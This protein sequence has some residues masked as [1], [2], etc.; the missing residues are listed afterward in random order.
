MKKK[1]TNFF[2][3]FFVSYSLLSIYV[4]LE[5][6]FDRYLQQ[7]KNIIQIVTIYLVVESFYLFFILVFLDII[8]NNKRVDNDNKPKDEDDDEY[9]ERER[10]IGLTTFYLSLIAIYCY[11]SLLLLVLL[12]LFAFL[13]VLLKIRYKSI[14]ID[15]YTHT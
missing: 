8:V 1:T 4:R 15:I 5:V 9:R 10:E 13:L 12:F 3:I 2:I 6:I 14:D 11:F 7:Q